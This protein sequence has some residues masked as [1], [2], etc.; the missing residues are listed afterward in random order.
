MGGTDNF[1]C[2]PFVCPQLTQVIPLNGSTAKI[3]LNR[4]QYK[5]RSCWVLIYTAIK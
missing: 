2:E 3:S 4:F 5:L 1:S